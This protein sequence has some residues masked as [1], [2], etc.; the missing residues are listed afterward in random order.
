LA[1]TPNLTVVPVTA[2]YVDVEGN[3]IAGQ[4]R[5]TPRAIITDAAYG[6]IIISNTIT[7]TLNS[8]GTFTVYLPATD[9]PDVS[10]TGWTY[11][12]VE[13]FT[14]GRTFDMAVPKDTV[15]SLNLATVVPAAANSGT[16]SLYV[17]LGQYA[18]VE[19]RITVV[20]GYS[21]DIGLAAVAAATSSLQATNASVQ[22]SLAAQ[23]VQTI[24]STVAAIFNPLLL[25]GA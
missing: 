23:G 8:S 25:G 1:L 16:A 18:G 22:A 2:T 13:A 3:A 17:S 15:G 24:Q 12:V 21:E 9:D 14:N 10:P 4:V 5:F 20:E 19:S 11:Q 6:Q 7:A